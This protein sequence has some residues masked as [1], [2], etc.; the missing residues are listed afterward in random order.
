MSGIV[1]QNLGRGSG[2]IKAGAID[3]NAVTLAKMAGLARGTLIHGDTSGDPAALAV[4]AADEVLTHDGTDFDWAAAAGGGISHDGSTANGVLTY[5]DADEA[6]VEANLTFDGTDLA[7]ASGNVNV[8]SGYGIDF[9][10]TADGGV[11]TPSELFDDYE[12]GTW[13]PTLG[14]NT[15]Y[16]IQSGKYTKIGRMVYASCVISVTSL[17]TGS[18]S[19]LSGFPFASVNA[20]GGNMGGGI[21]YFASLAVNVITPTLYKANGTTSTNFKSN[22]AAGTGISGNLAI[23]GNSARVDF[24]MTY[25]VS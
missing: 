9:S 2:L 12:E 7:I 24:S 10:A 11:S 15:S 16:S 20:G 8:A 5:K 4:G 3:D 25:E 6:T 21:F 22:T 1:G 18:T 23:F 13:T 14:G 17:G 19:L